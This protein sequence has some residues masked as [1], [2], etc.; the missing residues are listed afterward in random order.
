MHTGCKAYLLL[1]VNWRKR[2]VLNAFTIEIA[3]N[4]TISALRLT[5]KI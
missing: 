2:D 1:K 3:K 5:T 4:V